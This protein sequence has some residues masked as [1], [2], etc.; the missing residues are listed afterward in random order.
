MNFEINYSFSS[1]CYFGTCRVFNKLL[2]SLNVLAIKVAI[3]LTLL[4]LGTLG[5]SRLS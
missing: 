5:I 2:N 4:A 3:D 1:P